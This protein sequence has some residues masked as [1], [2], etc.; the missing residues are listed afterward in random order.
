M[1]DLTRLPIAT[2]SYRDPTHEWAFINV[3]S[4]AVFPIYFE[5]VTLIYDT[6]MILQMIDKYFGECLYPYCII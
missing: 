1:G 3:P 4:V 5:N 2:G 6:A